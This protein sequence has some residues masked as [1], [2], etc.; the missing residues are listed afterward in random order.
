MGLE[1]GAALAFDIREKQSLDDS[2]LTGERR[3]FQPVA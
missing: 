1:A 2:L 3:I